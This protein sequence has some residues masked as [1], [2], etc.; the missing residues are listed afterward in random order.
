MAMCGGSCGCTR[1][2]LRVGV[3]SR[4][5]RVMYF[6]Y[7]L[8]ISI[9]ARLT[10]PYVHCTLYNIHHT[11][12]K[13]WRN[14]ILTFHTSYTRSSVNRFFLGF[15][16]ETIFQIIQFLANLLVIVKIYFIK[17][18]IIQIITLHKY[19]K[20]TQIYMSHIHYTYD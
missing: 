6:S 1:Y 14:G 19:I 15:L 11:F 13:Q 17:D 2:E 10:L 3:S 4:R 7:S 5:G 16:F 18:N 12:G 8:E 9:V 20:S